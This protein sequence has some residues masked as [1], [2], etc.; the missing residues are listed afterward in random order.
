MK[1]QWNVL[2]NNT[3]LEKGVTIV[4]LLVVM[5]ILAIIFSF[6]FIGIASLRDRTVISTTITS[7]LSDIKQQQIK[8][9][10]GDTDGNPNRGPYGVYFA[11]SSYTVYPG[12]TYSAANT[13]NFMVGLDPTVRIQTT[14]PNNTLIFTEGSGELANFAQGQN[15]IIVSVS[16]TGEQKTITFNKYGVVT[17]VE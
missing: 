14:L 8:A 10:I 12:D 3:T 1:R 15:T 5:G 2:L 13:K 6:T 17:S 16:D 9:M 11:D 7:M 4:E